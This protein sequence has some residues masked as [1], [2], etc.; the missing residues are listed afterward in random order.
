MQSL[1]RALKGSRI[2]CGKPDKAAYISN[3]GLSEIKRILLSGKPYLG[4]EIH[5]HIGKEVHLRS[6]L[7]RTAKKKFTKQQEKEIQGM[8]KALADNV[9]WQFLMKHCKKEGEHTRKL[10]GVNV[11]VILDLKGTGKYKR[12]GA[13]LKTTSC[14]TEAAFIKSAIEK[15][16]Y[17]RQGWLY[18]EAEGLDNF[19]FIGVQKH[20]PHKV[21]ILD[22]ADY[23]KEEKAI[24]L[25][26]LFLIE[27]YK[28]FGRA[29]NKS[30]QNSKRKIAGTREKTWALLTRNGEDRSR[31]INTNKQDNYRR[32]L[33]QGLNRS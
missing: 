17:L 26:T 3:S 33:L 12:L 30:T 8:C 9:F 13:D 21:F 16:D 10:F 29:F 31:S 11:K 5:L 32:R 4:D 1:V 20:Y 25:E 27:L 14:K 23:A 24:A 19:Y 28:L 6:L 22:V 2:F 15:Y 18:K 7:F